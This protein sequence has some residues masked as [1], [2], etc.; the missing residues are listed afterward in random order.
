MGYRVKIFVVGKIKDNIDGKILEYPIIPRIGDILHAEF[1]PDD[2][3]PSRS[4]ISAYKVS[5]VT[6][7]QE[8]GKKFSAFVN[9]T[10][11]EEVR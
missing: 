6:L 2:K 7:L 8:N 1:I 9:V 3:H 11:D 10:V 5:N 4:K